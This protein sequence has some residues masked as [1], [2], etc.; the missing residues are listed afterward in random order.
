MAQRA[1][2]ILQ[3]EGAHRVHAEAWA[4]RLCRSGE[5]DALVERLRET[6]EHAGRWAGPANDPDVL[7][8]VE[9]GELRHDAAQQR[10]RVRVWLTD[11]LGAE[12][13][14]ITLDEP[15][16]WSRWDPELRRYAP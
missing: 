8:A 11:F 13:V 14:A 5:R 9:Q 16:D 7:A 10:E 15:T 4:R 12:G 6:W 1:R 3:E 2:K